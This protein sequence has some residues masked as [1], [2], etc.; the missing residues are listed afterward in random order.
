[1]IPPKVEYAGKDLE[2]M[3]FAKAYHRWLFDL[4][5]PF[6]GKHL[7]EVGAG[8]GSFSKMLLESGPESLTLVEPSSMFSELKT[9]VLPTRTGTTIN[10][11]N[12]IFSEIADEIRSA[13]QPDSILYI[14]VMEHI[15]DD[16][17]ELRIVHNTLAA[18]GRIFVFVPALPLLFSNFD[19]HIGHF[20]RYT[21]KELKEKCEQ[22]GFKL[23]LLRWF[24]MAGALPWLIK[25]RVLKSLKVEPGA[26]HAY[27]RLVVPVM[28]PIENLIHPPLGKNL[29]LIAEKE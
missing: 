10:L 19:R 24:D 25:Y 1:M 9:T 22:A 2:A 16:R 21:R 7:I 29:L 5:H 4:I 26:V 17:S 18:K 28:R 15:E 23:L 3:A 6:L 11:Y 8:T 12:N 14:N 13:N 20:R 27:D